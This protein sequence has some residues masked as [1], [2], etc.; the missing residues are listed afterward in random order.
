MIYLNIILT[1]ICLLL[2][3]FL[4]TLFYI[5]KRIS[6][7]VEKFKQKSGDGLPSMPN[8]FGGLQGM[9]NIFNQMNQKF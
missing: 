8:P 6:K 2:I 4:V 1:I 5:L 9:G 3:S 7:A